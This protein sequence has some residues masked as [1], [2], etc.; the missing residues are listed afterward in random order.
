MVIYIIH[1]RTSHFL[2]LLSVTYNGRKTAS[3]VVQNRGFGSVFIKNCGF[4][5]GLKTVNSPSKYTFKLEVARFNTTKLTRCVRAPF[6]ADQ[7]G[8]I[9]L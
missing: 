1:P 2:T 9:C 6:V 4:G 5:V 3:R 8:G 7:T